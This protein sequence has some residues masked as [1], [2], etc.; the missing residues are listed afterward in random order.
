MKETMKNV[1]KYAAAIGVVV[2]GSVTACAADEIVRRTTNK[3][4]DG[5]PK[6]LFNAAQFSLMYIVADKI[7]TWTADVCGKVLDA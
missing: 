6:W 5:M 3:V 1:A 4:S 7:A 2:S